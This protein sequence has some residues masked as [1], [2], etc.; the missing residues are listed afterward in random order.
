MSNIIKETNGFVAED[1]VPDH[2]D[3]PPVWG[4]VAKKVEAYKK[5][6]VGASS[7]HHTNTTVERIDQQDNSEPQFD[8]D[9]SAPAHETEADTSSLGQRADETQAEQPLPDL[10]LLAEESFNKGVQA[11]IERMESDYG[12]SIRTLQAICEHLND[13]RDTIL[14]NSMTEMKDLV[15]K[16]SEK[17]IRHSV[18][19]Q[20]E[21]IIKVV[22][23]SIQQAVKSD[24]F[25]ISVNPKDYDSIQARSKDFISSISG[26]ENIIIRSDEN[27]EQGG[28]LVESS[29]CTVD[30]TLAS[31]LDIIAEYIK[32][33]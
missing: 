17:I 6:A 27:I 25:I 20:Q 10:E 8:S 9:F 12:T 24:E 4:E 33:N 23:E 28:C 1:L 13:I 32:E 7:S 14:K 30:A 5:H 15:L 21:T 18:A 22:E 19:S 29:N 2:H 31:Q 11:G 3:L 16:I 26:L